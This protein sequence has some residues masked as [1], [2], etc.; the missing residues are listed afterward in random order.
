[1]GVHLSKVSTAR[2]LTTATIATVVAVSVPALFWGLG[3]LRV[4][5]AA[6]TKATPLTSTDDQSTPIKGAD[7][8][9][10]PDPV[11]PV[12]PAGS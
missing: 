1:V 6:L 10:C 11:D 7:D 12:G 4:L 5:G 3:L 2:V 9:T 8:A